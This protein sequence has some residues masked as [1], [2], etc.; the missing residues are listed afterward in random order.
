MPQP[1]AVRLLGDRHI[2]P[3]QKPGRRQRARRKRSKQGCWFWVYQPRNASEFKNK[4]PNANAERQD[5]GQGTGKIEKLIRKTRRH[6]GAHNSSHSESQWTGSSGPV[7][8]KSGTF[9]LAPTASAWWAQRQTSV[10][11]VPSK[12]CAKSPRLKSVAFEHLSEPQTTYSLDK[13]LSLR[14]TA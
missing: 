13:N 2:D 8:H 10:L 5:G 7:R 6:H 14:P 3:D 9:L 12:G 4:T 1:P 11:P